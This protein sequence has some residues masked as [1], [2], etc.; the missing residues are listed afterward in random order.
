MFNSCECGLWCPL[1]SIL[2]PLLF[3]IYVND[4]P[5]AVKCKLLLDADDSALLIAGKSAVDIQ[6]R[7]SSELQS[8]REWLIDN[9]L[10]LHLG[11]T[12]SI[13]FGSK[14]R[15]NNVES[16]DV[17]CDG[18]SLASKSCVKYLGVVLDQSLSGSQ[19]A[20]TFIS[21]SNAKLK[22]L[23]RQTRQFDMETKKTTSF[24]S[25]T[26]SFRL[27]Q[28]FLVFWFNQEIQKPSAN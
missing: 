17:T 8:V 28:R 19:S 9:K 1:G 7:L 12:E 11:K 27:R 4:I 15:L 5:S 10:S 24:S 13:L 16:I 14:Q 22:F 20:D 18:Q 21:K 25:N 6:Q 3:L 2:G 26:V 23:Y